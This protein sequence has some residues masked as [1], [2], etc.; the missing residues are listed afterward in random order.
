MVDK[1]ICEERKFQAI[2][3]VIYLIVLYFKK[4]IWSIRNKKKN[5]KNET[6]VTAEMN[7]LTQSCGTKH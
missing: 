3:L 5:L 7:L 1:V 2:K 6:V 4:R